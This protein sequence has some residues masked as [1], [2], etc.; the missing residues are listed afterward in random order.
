MDKSFTVIRPDGWLVSISGSPNYRT[1][2]EMRLDIV[3]SLLL[4]IVGLGV[5]SKAR[6]AAVNY[7]F[8]F[9]KPSGAELAQI[10][11]L[12]AKGVI[13]PVIDRIFPIS[14]CQSAIEYSA[15]GRVRGKVVISVID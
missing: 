11:L 6:K 5:N 14:E 7:R 13:K 9:M 10:A 8:I 2:K 15:S 4:G 12:V 1:A 3:R